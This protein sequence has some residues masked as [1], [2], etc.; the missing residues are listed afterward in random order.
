MRQGNVDQVA[1]IQE[2]ACDKRGREQFVNYHL[3]RSFEGRLPFG[4]GKLLPI[5]ALAP[6]M[7]APVAK[8]LT[9]CDG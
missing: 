7:L 1:L 4:H 8:W 3:S 5:S 2:F 9:W 6:R